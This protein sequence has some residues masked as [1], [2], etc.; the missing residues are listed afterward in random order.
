MRA[1]RSRPRP[2]C[3]AMKG[4]RFQQAAMRKVAEYLIL[5]AGI[6]ALNC[7]SQTL[8]D[9]MSF[10]TGEVD[11]AHLYGVSAFTGYSTS[12]YPVSQ[13]IQPGASGIGGDTNYGATA[14]M[15]WQR[16]RDWM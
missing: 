1:R 4:R 11:G 13:G 7:K 14:S 12:A 10:R 5:T 2:A 8:A 15:G 16:H 3:R 6:L 9:Q